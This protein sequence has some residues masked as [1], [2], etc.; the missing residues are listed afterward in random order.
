MENKLKTQTL[1]KN[2]LV[3]EGTTRTV[4]TADTNQKTY[5][6]ANNSNQT[7]PLLTTYARPPKSSNRPTT[8]SNA[9]NIN[10]FYP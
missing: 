2:E 8:S 4:G 9:V 6:S 5:E 7:K 10:R 1:S 3:L